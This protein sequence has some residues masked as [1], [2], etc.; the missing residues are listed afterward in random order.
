MVMMRGPYCGPPARPK[1]ALP[2]AP[3]TLKFVRLKGLKASAR[4]CRRMRLPSPDGHT[5][6]CLINAKLSTRTGGWRN[7]L[8]YCEDVPNESWP[9]TEKAAALKKR[10]A[11][12]W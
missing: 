6:T 3:L 10:L 11:G 8:L 4:N 1:L 2:T 7:L 5:Y 9:G 12:L